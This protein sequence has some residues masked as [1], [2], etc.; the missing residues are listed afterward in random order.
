MVKVSV[1]IPAYNEEKLIERCL[2]SL[3]HQTMNRSN[4]EV[5]VVNN[6]S[7]DKTAQI[8]QKYADK[9]ILEKRKGVLFARQTGLI[10]A[11]SQIILRTDADGYVPNNWVKRG[12]QN[13]VKNPDYVAFSGFYLPDN[14]KKTLKLISQF[15]IN[16]RKLLYS[17]GGKTEWLTGSCSAIRK[18]AFLKIGG[19]DFKADPVIED[20]Q[21]IG[22]R[23]AKLGKIGFD[24]NWWVWYSPRRFNHAVNNKIDLFND[25]LLYQTLNNLYYFIFKK[26]PKKV[27]GKWQDIR[28]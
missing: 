16:F 11:K 25:Y 21:G 6:N 26:N 24:A 8:A 1:V 27:L 5:I 10:K 23:L 2:K 14:E 7:S 20:Q 22:H 15:A 18:E 19:Y 12:Y 28:E 4:Y 17:L 13:L 9:V 3:S